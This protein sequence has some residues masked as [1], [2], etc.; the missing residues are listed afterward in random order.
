MRQ[1][2]LIRREHRIA[3]LSGRGAGNQGLAPEYKFG[4]GTAEDKVGATAPSFCAP[5]FPHPA[6][7]QREYGQRQVGTKK[8]GNYLP[9]ILFP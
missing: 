7:G 8:G 4:S 6:T 9:S 2:P 3:A 1:G 5:P